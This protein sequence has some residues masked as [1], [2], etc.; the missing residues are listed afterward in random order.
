MQQIGGNCDLDWFRRVPGPENRKIKNPVLNEVGRVTKSTKCYPGPPPRTPNPRPLSST[1]S[2]RA[3]SGAVEQGGSSSSPISEVDSWAELW[4]VGK[5]CYT[6]WVQIQPLEKNV[7]TSRFCDI[8]ETSQNSG[9]ITGTPRRSISHAVKS[10]Q[11]PYTAKIKNINNV[12]NQM[13]KSLELRLEG[14]RGG[15]HHLPQAFT[16]GPGP[17][18]QSFCLQHARTHSD[19]PPAPQ[20]RPQILYI[21]MYI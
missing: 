14:Q 8:F 20:A 19:C 18:Q 6:V 5:I 16:T 9:Q 13:K 10:S 15:G 21:Y 17:K 11:M 12:N 7:Y 4:L 1:T 2:R 3:D